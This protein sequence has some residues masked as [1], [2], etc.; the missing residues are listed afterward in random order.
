MECDTYQ[1]Q[2]SLWIDNQL[3]QDEIRQIEAHTATCLSCRATLDA[4]RRVDRLLT[5]V[6]MMTPAPGFTTR[7][8]ARLV[9]RRRRR[10]TWAGILTLTLATLAL[11]LGAMVLL[12]ISGVALWQS[13]SASGLLTQ[14]IGLLL[15]LGK[16]LAASL[17]LAWLVVG[18]L[19]R[20]LRHPV[21]IAYAMATAILVV[22]W[23]QVVTRRVL[24]HR[25]VTVNSHG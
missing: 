19:A 17:G 5:S 3:A 24:A 12:G 18:A 6:P 13:L 23:T 21:F 22:T 1:E 7:F 14:I 25:P 8:Q 20:G 4:L 16:V 2:I 9:A 10:R 15:D 11:L